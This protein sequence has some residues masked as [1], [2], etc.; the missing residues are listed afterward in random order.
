MRP[1]RRI[2]S[3]LLVDHLRVGEFHLTIYLVSAREMARLN[4][5]YLRHMGSTDV[6]AFD[7]HDSAR[8]GPLFGEIFVCV[9]E[10]CAQARRFRTTWPAELV[11]Y[12]IH[13]LLHLC[14][15]N[16]RQRRLR[17][18]MK[19]VENRLLMRLAVRMSLETVAARSGR[20]R[21][22]SRQSVAVSAAAHRNA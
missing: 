5:K 13:G 4:E 21:S 6:L 10:A 1:L 22:R 7:Y 14:G 8:P 2:A 9:E 18:K 16:D 11:R 3:A 20:P 12:V 19:R 15:Y 17:L